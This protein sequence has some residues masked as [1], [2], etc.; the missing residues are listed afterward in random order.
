MHTPLINDI[1]KILNLDH[2]KREFLWIGTQIVL[3]QGLEDLSNMVKVLFPT[4]FE[5]KDVV[6][7][8]YHE[9]VGERPQDV[10]Y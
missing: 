4:F 5:D 6:Q 2:M 1:P 8:H 10:I 7:I 3:T 9:L